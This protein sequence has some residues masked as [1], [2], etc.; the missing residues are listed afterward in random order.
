ME[1]VKVGELK[2][3]IWIYKVLEMWWDKHNLE[4]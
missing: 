1:Y 2:K 4:I 3:Y